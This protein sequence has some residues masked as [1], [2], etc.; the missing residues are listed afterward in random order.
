MINTEIT[1]L[2]NLMNKAI[3]NME[4]ATRRK[5]REF[6]LSEYKRLKNKYEE[7]MEM[8]TNFLLNY[9]N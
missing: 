8:Y 7:E 4:K 5:D 9:Y 2:Q 6:F 3:E 1:N